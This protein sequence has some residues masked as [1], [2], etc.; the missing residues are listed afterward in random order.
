MK[1]PA[2]NFNN[3]NSSKY[4]FVRSNSSKNN[5]EN[6]QISDLSALPYVYP[7]R[8]KGKEE[9]S[10]QSILRR[11]F[12]YNLPCMYSGVI[13]IDPKALTRWVN[14]GLYNKSATMVLQTLEPYNES[15]SGME[16]KTLQLIS[17]RAKIHPDKTVKEILIEVV[18]IYKRRLRKAQTPIFRELMT[19]ADA[20]P[21][22][23]KKQFDELMS[24]TEDRLNEQPIIMPFSSYEF[25]YKLRKI[26]EDIY[27]GHDIEAK[28][29]MNRVLKET[30]RLAVKTTPATMEQQ[31]AAIHAIENHVNKSVLKDDPQLKELLQISKA[32]LT[33]KEIIVPFSRKQFLY[34][35]IK[36]IKELPDE[37]LKDELIRVAEKLPTSNESFPAYIVKLSS[38]PADKILQRIVWGY[39]ASVEHLKPKSEGGDRQNMSNLGA[40]RTAL[41]SERK[42]RDFTLWLTEHPE[43]RKNCQK[44]VDKLIE[45]YH[46]G[47][48]KKHGIDP[49]YIKDFK[50]TIYKLSNYTLELD[51]SKL[52]AEN[53]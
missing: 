53:K 9:T 19:V 10:G 1:V 4:R 47:V 13:M 24:V 18:P 34:D 7:V 32:R 52:Y 15:F 30:K 40:A 50:M 39:L 51:I 48:F 25:K 46:D 11:L 6:E 23:Y 35:L 8:F 36:I 28:K 43:A 41:N 14:S 20:L 2:V 33:K 3:M 45:L 16:A 27:N 12:A 17:E 26:N 5:D 21:Y 29:V 31:I 49:K 42:S 38:E 44:Y 37:D 22:E